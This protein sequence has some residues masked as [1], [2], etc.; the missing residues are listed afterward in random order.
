MIKKI[1][2]LYDAIKFE[3][4]IFDLPFAYLGMVL[5]AYGIPTLW[6]IA[7][8][9]LAMAGARSFAMALNPRTAMRASLQRLL[10]FALVSFALFI[11]VPWP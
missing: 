11:Y 4:T 7:W 8:I 1:K 2:T 9:T 3:H 10:N 5:A 6:Q